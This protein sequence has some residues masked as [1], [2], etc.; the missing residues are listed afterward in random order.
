MSVQTISTIPGA[1]LRTSRRGGRGAFTLI[2]ILI[3]VAL[4]GLLA[5]IVIPELGSASRQ[6]REGVMKD[7]LR[8]MREQIFRYKIQHDDVGPGYPAG[9]P[10]GAPSEAAFIA[11]MTTHTDLFGNADPNGS[12]TFKYGPYLTKIPDNPLTGRTGILVVANGGA[13]PAPDSTQPYGWIYKP[14][15]SE[16]MPNQPGTDLVGKAY[17]S[18]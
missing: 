9:N 11:Q 16:F 10:A 12:N 8:F 2:E 3:V 7:D 13:I 6:A 15:T 4:L 1:P 18:Y 17:T 5:A 14:E